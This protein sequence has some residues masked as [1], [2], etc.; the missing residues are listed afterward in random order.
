MINLTN[1]SKSF[2]SV[3]AV[4]SLSFTIS[5]GEIVGLLG[6]NGAGKSTT[7]RMMTGFLSPDSGSISMNGL[8]ILD[9]S[10]QVQKLIGYLPENNPLYI[11]MLVSEILEY[12]LS[13]K[14]VPYKQR[15]E[16]IHFAVTR[17]GIGEV[18]YQPI[19]QLSKGFRQ[20][21]GLA[22]ALLHKPQILI[23]DE[24]SEGLDPNQRQEIRLLISSLAKHHTVIMSTHVM[25]EVEAVCT[26]MIIINKGQI[27]ADGSPK[28]LVKKTLGTG[29]RFDI[30]GTN[31]SKYLTKSFGEELFIHTEKLGHV[32]GI[33]KSKGKEKIQ[34]EVSKLAAKHKW[35]VW[36]ITEEHQNLEA[37]FQQL[38]QIT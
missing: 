37:V 3:T 38:T 13:L 14:Q 16:A 4:S 5:P 8:S 7:M 29:V 1:V 15:K 21:V 25:Q 11:D 24:P 19:Q 9:E 31:I 2:G 33:I 17:T 22:I 28:S 30:E 12:S 18:Y 27:V 36:E 10:N 23:L 20:R 6:P 34:P 26:R 32:K 35:V